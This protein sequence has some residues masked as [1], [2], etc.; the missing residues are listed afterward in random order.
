MTYGSNVMMALVIA[1]LILVSDQFVAT[2]AQEE[3][4]VNV[5]RSGDGDTVLVASPEGS[6]RDERCARRF[7]TYLVEDRMCENDTTLQR[8]KQVIKEDT[9][10]DW[11][12]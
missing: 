4:M 1:L 8:S 6:C 9:L 10:F 3:E 5:T 7:A 11:S 2:S 12:S